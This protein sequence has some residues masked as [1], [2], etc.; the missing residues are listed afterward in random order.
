MEEENEAW[1][2]N[3]PKSIH[4]PRQIGFASW[5]A[6][7]KSVPLI[8]TMKKK[9]KKENYVLHLTGPHTSQSSSTLEPSSQAAFVL[10]PGP[11]LSLV[12]TWNQPS[13]HT[14]LMHSIFVVCF[15]KKRSLLWNLQIFPMLVLF[16]WY[17]I[18]ILYMM[19]RKK[20]SQREF[21]QIQL[22]FLKIRI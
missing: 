5:R 12:T 3:I 6:G 17:D 8:D 11:H 18:I 1:R 13:H 4:V 2:F 19:V 10:P 15:L 7:L 9:I 14:L 21:S 16:T 20:T 22:F